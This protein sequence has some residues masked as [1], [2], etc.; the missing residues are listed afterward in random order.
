MKNMSQIAC[1]NMYKKKE[2]ELLNPAKIDYAGFFEK[3]LPPGSLKA[4]LKFRIIRAR[5]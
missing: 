4:L 3:N 5:K 2:R 1:G